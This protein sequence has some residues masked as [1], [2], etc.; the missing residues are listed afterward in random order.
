MMS[1]VFTFYDDR[2]IL[3]ETHEGCPD[4]LSIL[5]EIMTVVDILYD[6]HYPL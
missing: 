5:T 1:V 4:C 2:Y 3:I 6:D